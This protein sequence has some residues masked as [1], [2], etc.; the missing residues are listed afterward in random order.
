MFL[1]RNYA[2]KAN[3][4]ARFGLARISVGLF[5]FLSAFVSPPV[6][7][8]RVELAAASALFFLW[9]IVS[10]L[11]SK[12]RTNLAP[13]EHVPVFV[14]MAL[15]VLTLL[16]FHI[17]PMNVAPVVFL[18]PTVGLTFL[19]GVAGAIFVITAF[20]WTAMLTGLLGTTLIQQ[21]LWWVLVLLWTALIILAA[22][23]Q[24]L[25]FSH[26]YRLPF[27]DRLHRKPALPEATPRAELAIKN[28]TDPLPAITPQ[29]IAAFELPFQHMGVRTQE[30]RQDIEKAVQA[31]YG[32]PNADRQALSECLRLLLL[33]AKQNWTGLAVFSPREREILELLPQNISYK[34]MSCRLH[35]STSTIKT[36][37]Y[38][39]FQKLDISNR[40]QA[41]MLIRERGWFLLQEQGR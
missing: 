28:A 16:V 25:L 10:T 13:L 20:A 23:V 9:G 36:H 35:V 32:T 37:I 30:Y 5:L 33:A 15:C 34:E 11:W 22:T 40:E 2:A 39:I 26:P 7:T 41:I 6:G 24:M 18:L 31:L 1:S 19:Y 14:D 17:L 27:L 21:P 4:F 29:V 8:R 38:H 3:P 12:A